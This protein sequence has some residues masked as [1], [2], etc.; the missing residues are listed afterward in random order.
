[1]MLG[2]TANAAS[3]PTVETALL[4]GHKD[5]KVNAQ[6]T[7]GKS[8]LSYGLYDLALTEAVYRL[9]DKQSTCV[10]IGANIGY[11]SSLFSHCGRSV[12]SFEPHPIIFQRLQENCRRL[13]NA[14]CYP[15]A[16]DETSGEAELFIPA[17]FDANEGIASLRPVDKATSV[18]VK[19]QKFDEVFPN[20][21]IDIIKIDVEGHE[22]SVFKG[23]T[24]ALAN[25]RIKNILFEDFEGKKSPVVQYL[26]EYGYSVYRLVKSF[27]HLTFV[28]IDEA[29]E[30]P[31]WEPPNYLATKATDLA[32]S[33]KSW[34][35]LRSPLV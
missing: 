2:R 29:G 7:I 33:K 3:G 12:S 30:I 16:L 34:S 28:P 18:K 5:F 35:I 31:L 24:S 1:M 14:K 22:L 19:T 23:A 17:K 32:F 10:D 21:K 15:V 27:T 20:E 11:F 26:Q 4:W 8:I 9:T 13:T 25:N 6:E